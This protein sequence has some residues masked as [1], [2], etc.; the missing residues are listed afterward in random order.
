M[1]SNKAAAVPNICARLSAQ[2]ITKCKRYRHKLFDKDAGVCIIV[3]TACRR[4]EYAATP[5]R[6]RQ[7]KCLAAQRHA[8]PAPAGRAPS[9]VPGERF[10][11]PGRYRSGQVRDAPPGPC[12][13]PPGFP[14][15]RRIWVFATLVLSGRL[16]LRTS[17]VGRVDSVEERSQKRPQTHAGS[18]GVPARNAK[19]GADAELRATGRPR[20]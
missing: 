1:M 20:E 8:Q 4:R 10:L 7:A 3:F 9:A 11:R 15:R 18:D 16:R 13:Q 12:R 14:G 2:K 6:D 5:K 19:S 17:W